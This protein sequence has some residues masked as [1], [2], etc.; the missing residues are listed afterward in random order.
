VSNH[1]LNLGFRQQEHR[2]YIDVVEVPNVQDNRAESWVALVTVNE[3]RQG[4]IAPVHPRVRPRH[5][6]PGVDRDFLSR[7]HKKSRIRDK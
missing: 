2:N 4:Q 6:H 5:L 7:H 1:A 3:T